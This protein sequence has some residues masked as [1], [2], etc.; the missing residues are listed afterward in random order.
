M[1]VKILK[2]KIFLIT[3]LLFLIIGIGAVSAE[4]VNQSDENL[5]IS[6]SYILSVG[7]KTFKD[8]L[9]DI[10][11]SPESG[12]DIQTDY[13]FSNKTDAAF[14]QEGIRLNIA[15]NGKY[16][17]EGNNHVIDADNQANVFKITSGTVYINNLKIRNCDK[18][19]IILNDCILYTNNVTFE[20][21]HDLYEGAAIYA[22]GSNYYSTN[23]KFT[24]NYAKNGASIYALNSRVN[25]DGSTFTNNKKIGWGVIYAYNSITTVKNSIFA[26]MTSDYATA[27]YCEKEELTVFNS[28]FSNLFAVNTAGAIGLKKTASVNIEKCSF[29]NTSSSRN[30]GAI[31]A[32]LNGDNYN[33]T[34]DV[35]IKSSLF[36][37]CSSEFGGAYLQLGGQITIVG[38]HLISNVAKYSGGAVYLS[39]TTSLIGNCKVN[40]NSADYLEGGALFIDDSKVTVSSC[41]I[42]NNSARTLG[43][44]IYLYSSE[45]EIKNNYFADNNKEVIVS[46]FDRKGS[47]L[48]NNDLNGGKTLLNQVAY[49]QVVDYEGK[50]IILD[51]T[52]KVNET[53]SS[54]KFDLRDYHLA[55]VVKDQGAMGSCWAFGATGALESAFL[56][57]TGILLDLSENNIKN[58][59]LHYGVYGTTSVYET[60]YVSS[61]M[62]LFLSWLGTISVNDDSYDE[63]GKISLSQFTGDSFHIQDSILI[64]ARTGA[65][66]NAKLKDALINYGGLTVHIYGA[67][68]NN[69][70]YN[71][72]THAQYY[73]GKEDGNHFVTLVGWDDNYS[74]DNFLIKPKGN[75]AWI[76]KNSWGTDWGEDGYFYVSYYD[77]SFAMHSES[78]GYII[79]N[80]EQYAR[81]YQYDIGDM[82]RFFKINGK[83][84]SIV[85]TYTAVDNELVSAVGTYFETA[86]ENY[87]ITVYVDGKAVYSQNGTSDHAGFSTIKLNK[88]IAVNY[89]HKFSVEIKEKSVPLIGDT[90][91]IFEKGNSIIYYPDNTSEDLG[92]FKQAACIKA[93]T[94]KNN[95]PQKSQTQYYTKNSMVTVKSNANGKKISIA[96][97]NKVVGSA[98]VKDGEATFDLKLGPGAY[99]II[100]PYDDENDDELV[101][102]FEIIRTINVNESITIGYKAQT[103]LEIEFID[104]YGVELFDTNISY[105]LDGRNYTGTIEDNDGILYIDL[106]DLSIGTHTLVLVNPETLEEVNVTIKVVSRFA[107]NSNVYMY[108]A[109]GSSFKVRVYGDDGNPVGANE[110]VVM[111]L[112]NVKYKVKTDSNGYATLTIP[113]TVNPGKYSL[114]ATYAGQTIKNKV[115]VKQVLK[116]AK[117][118]IKKSAKKLVIAAVLKQGK[119]PIKSKWVTFKFNGKTYSAKTNK[120]GIAKI[121]IKQYVLKNLKVGKKVTYQV[122]YYKNTVKQKV[123]VKK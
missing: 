101:E 112:N 92:L 123:K 40:E 3:A 25:V 28:L 44:G 56:K 50:K 96:K 79:K 82:T 35:A 16:T 12:L 58:S 94:F 121:T 24:E 90:R 18:S 45:Y 77:T 26:N 71:K 31:F 19:S 97:N 73:N 108:H 111:T 67:V 36:E 51:P 22:S 75:G 72:N 114:F 118:T 74:K 55:G 89:G 84:M 70:Y 11:R 34:S 5:E 2:R 115:K 91:I 1:E 87:V 29:I 17:I 7:E 66:D 68:S 15:E 100:T 48:K 85:N 117:V 86:N 30:G 10:D 120:Y 20:N 32:D 61:A 110:I 81:A 33:A 76:C 102:L 9:D 65:L 104:E 57:A 119:T 105:K 60:G 103:N 64:P 39:N 80:T 13:K 63:L 116:L 95:N 49:T 122:T 4:D 52:I 46:Y 93:Y 43:S 41:D 21:N 99:S 109:D 107:A 6:D 54:P 59:A 78:A 53:A 106:S 14:K 69:N 113:N 38:S 27:I 37:N 42:V 62:G 98:T 83:E 23:D 88:K 8:L 47:S